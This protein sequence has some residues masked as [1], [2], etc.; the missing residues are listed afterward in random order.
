MVPIDYRK[1]GKD[2]RIEAGIPVSEA[3]QELFENADKAKALKL[4]SG[5][6]KQEGGVSRTKSV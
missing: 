3:E 1:S 6:K 4:L 5:T 2:A